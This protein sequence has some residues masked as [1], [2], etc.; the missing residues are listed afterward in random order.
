MDKRGEQLREN[1][2]SAWEKYGRG[3]KELIE[4]SQNLDEYMNECYYR[5]IA[6]K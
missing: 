4:A 1:M 2:Y 3:S 5:K 6:I